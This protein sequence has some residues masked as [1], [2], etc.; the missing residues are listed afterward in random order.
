MSKEAHLEFSNII[1]GDNPIVR[2]KWFEVFKDPL[3]VPRYNLTLN[4]QRE[5]AFKKL[6]KVFQSKI[7]SV[8]DFITNPTNI[9]TAHEFLGQVDPSSAT[10]FTV[11]MNLFGGSI[12]ALGTE[13]HQHLFD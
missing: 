12:V 1:L 4:E 11:Q 13:R 9:F 5:E 10:K 7:V 2:E 3:W 8:K 6:K